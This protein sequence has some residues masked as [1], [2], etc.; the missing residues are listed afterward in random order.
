[1]IG[2]AV[3][4]ARRST[5]LAEI[6]RSVAL[7]TGGEPGAR[8]ARRLAIPVSPD[9]LLR[10]ILRTPAPPRPTPIL[11]LDDWAYRKGRR[12]GTILV[13]LARNQV[14]D[15]LPDRQAGTVSTWLQA[16]PRVVIIA[17]DRAGAYAD[18]CR[19]GAPQA[20]QVADR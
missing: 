19:D 18:G 6:Q 14:V 16:H 4:S 5:R 15:L 1:L 7:A 2:I 20:V 10:L 11:G 17:R 3:R 8:L 12:Y 13:D 9:T